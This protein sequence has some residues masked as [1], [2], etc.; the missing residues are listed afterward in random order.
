MLFQLP[1]SAPRQ[2]CCHPVCGC[3]QLHVAAGCC[4][5]RSSAC[6]VSQQL[7]LSWL[8]TEQEQRQRFQQQR[9][10][11]ERFAQAD[12][13]CACIGRLEKAAYN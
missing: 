2:A 7:L 13:V 11:A 3:L 5:S 6:Q 8:R 4:R 12:Q 10:P 9:L 1:L